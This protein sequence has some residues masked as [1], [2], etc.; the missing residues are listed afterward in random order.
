MAGGKRMAGGHQ[1]ANEYSGERIVMAII[2][3]A[4]KMAKSQ[5]VGGIGSQRSTV[6]RRATLW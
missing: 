3:E 6:E 2:S 4:K 1:W 5:G